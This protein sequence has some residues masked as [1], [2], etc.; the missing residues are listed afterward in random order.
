MN[1]TIN[2]SLISEQEVKSVVLQRDPTDREQSALTDYARKHGLP[3]ACRLLLNS[4][5]FSFV[6]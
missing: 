5:E 1:T 4:N 6:D 3:N 2:Q